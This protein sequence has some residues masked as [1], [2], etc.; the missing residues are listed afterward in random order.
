MR[1]VLYL[2]VHTIKE[3]FIEDFEVKWKVSELLCHVYSAFIKTNEHTFNNTTYSL[4]RGG[5]YL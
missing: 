3:S 2:K 1:N 5:K 4:K